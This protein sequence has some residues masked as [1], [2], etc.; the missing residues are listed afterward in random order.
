VK[1]VRALLLTFVVSLAFA[2]PG[3][4]QPYPPQQ[5][6]L[7]ASIAEPP[8]DSFECSAG[9]FCPD[10]TVAVSF[11]GDP[12]ASV[13]ADSQGNA[14]ATIRVPEDAPDG[15]ATITFEGL[16]ADCETIQVLSAGFTVD[17]GLPRTGAE[18]VDRWMALSGGLIVVGGTMVLYGRRRRTR[19]S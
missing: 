15:P 12:V 9:S 6:V 19:V 13:T 18:G 2:A 10:T 7:C 14:T 5:A 11:N 3:L 4:A 16:G 1:I 8:G 17:S